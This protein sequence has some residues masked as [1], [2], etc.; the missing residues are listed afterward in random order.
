MVRKIVFMLLLILA[1]SLVYMPASATRNVKA[2]FTTLYDIEGSRLDT[3]NT[4]MVSTS[5][6]VSWNEYGTDLRGSPGF[7]RNDPTPSMKNIESEDSD[8][9][10]F[11]NLDEI[12]NLT[13]PGD[14][15]DHPA[16]AETTVAMTPEET[17]PEGAMEETPEETEE[18]APEEEAPGF[19]F[20][21]V[22]IVM[23][24]IY[25]IRRK[26]DN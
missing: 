14:P 25:L 20:G 24:A 17:E 2:E 10:G 1:V 12:N 26:K 9:D 23:S 19:G 22:M 3:C 13:F 11:T 7:D 4:C 15:D 6:P 21:L 16:P 18:M 5:I 8:G